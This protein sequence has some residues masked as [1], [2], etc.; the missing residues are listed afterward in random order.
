MNEINQRVAEYWSTN[1]KTARLINW[2]EHPV[3]VA[4]M[5]RR[6]SGDPAMHAYAW[7]R[8]RYLPKPAALSLVL[9]CGTGEF[10][11]GAAP[12]GFSEHFHAND[13]SAGAIERARASAQ[14][15][16]L[17]DVI[18]YAVADLNSII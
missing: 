6:S 16:G 11:R 18:D 14:A 1:R 5:N 2:I 13:I 4:E 7:F 10:E 17:G 12:V 15:E 8:A 9:G 3:L